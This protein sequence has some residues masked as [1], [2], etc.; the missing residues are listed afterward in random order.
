MKQLHS[1]QFGCPKMDTSVK[2]CIAPNP[3]QCFFVVCCGALRSGLYF[4]VF[5]GALRS[6]FLFLIVNKLHILQT[7]FED[8]KN[9]L[10]VV[11]GAHRK[12]HLAAKH[13]ILASLTGL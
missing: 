7:S 10:H 1:T 9:A 5:C 12:D 6:G 4:L 8:L 3:L 11:K 13:N 2:V